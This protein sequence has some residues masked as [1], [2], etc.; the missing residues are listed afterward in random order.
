[1]T[2]LSPSHVA[3]AAQ[4]LNGIANKTPV[5]TSRT[6]NK[7]TGCQIFLKCENFQRVGAFKFRGAYNAISQLSDAQKAAGVITHSSGNHAQGVALAA[8]LLGVKATIVM[9]EDAPAIKRAATAGYGAK[10][11][12]CAAIEREKVTAELIAQHGYTLI[13]PYDNDHVIAGQGTAAWELFDEIG[14]LDL[15]FTPVGGGGLISGSALATA[16]QSPGCRV[17]GVEPELGDDAN[18]SWRANTIYTLDHVP[19]TMAD[20]LRTRFIGQRNL[21]VMREYVA[22][23]TAV[24][25]KAILETL[26]FL[27]TR[28]KIIVEPSSAVALAPLFTGQYQAA[29]KRVGVILSGGNV[30][31]EAIGAKFRAAN[32]AV[33][34]P[35]AATTPPE[36]AAPPE[37][38]KRPQILV[39]EDIDEA[40]LDILRQTADLTIAPQLNQETFLQ[41]IGEYEAIIVGP[42]RQITDQMIEYG[43]NLRAI[44]NLSSHLDNIDVSTARDVGIEVRNAPDNSAVAIAEHTLTRLLLLANQFGDGRLAGKT[45]GLIGFGNIGKQVA[46]RARAFDMRIIVNQPRL[47]PE[48]ALSVGAEVA[49]LANLLPQA[50][51]VSLHVPFKAETNAFIGPKNLGKMKK[52]ACLINTGHTDLLNEA[53]LLDALENGRIAGAALSTLPAEVSGDTAVAD[54]VRRHPRVIVSPHVTTILGQQQKD[55]AITVAKQIAEILRSKQ[56]NET[57]ALELVPTEQVLPHEQID[58]KR[59]ARLMSRLEEDGRLVNPPVTTFWNGQYIVLDGATRSTA[60]K[61]LGYEYLIVQVAQPEREGFELHTWYHAISSPQPFADLYAQLKTIEGLILTPLPDNRVRAAFRQKDAL[62]YFLDRDGQATLAEVASGADRLA[63]MNELVSRYTAWGSVERTLIT[64]LPRLLGQ[65]PEMTAVAIFPQFE[66]ETVFEVASRGE[67]LPAGLTRF[68]IPGRI[69][70]LNADLERLKKEESLPAKRGWFNQF[71]EEKL[72][73]SRMRYYQ[74]PVILLDE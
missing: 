11:V 38:A 29:G 40:A 1:M 27:W 62:C 72:A 37:P 70:R 31:V 50:D 3:A 68:V 16:V 12:P 74:E 17:I 66:P 6:L 20:G 52:T 45:L 30:D 25:E 23:M 44:G 56:A 35:T 39:C 36:A 24:S 41:E 26:H 4:R 58:D 57:L 61:R 59:V 55:I 28:L 5:L 14:P 65:F 69:L 13:H 10:I 34:P 47:T 19:D 33:S 60:F 18:R 15:L 67:L 54:Q 48:L 73:R 21:A 42:Q 9:P 8:Q 46:K 7:R 22:D 71:L 63:V 32:A 43:F 64:D 49:D 2:H 51:F 53:A